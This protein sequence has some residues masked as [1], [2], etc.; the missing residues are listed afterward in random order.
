MGASFP[1]SGSSAL[2]IA[3]AP[4]QTYS[5]L[6][7]LCTNL[8]PNL[9]LSPT[10]SVSVSV[11]VVSGLSCVPS[12]P[13]TLAQNAA[14][15]CTFN[16]TAPGTL[17]GT[18]TPPQTVQFTGITN[19]QNDTNASNNIV[20]GVAPSGQITIVIDAIDDSAT[21]PS[22]T[23]GTVPLLPNDQLGTTTNPSVGVAG[24]TA[25]VVVPG[26]NTTLPGATIVGNDVVVQPGTPS[27]VYTVEYRICA[28]A[29]PTVCDT[30]IVT[31]TIPGPANV[32]PEKIPTLDP[33]LLLG[34]ILL[35][36]LLGARG[37][38][39]RT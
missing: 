17:G 13:A 1:A 16:Y 9:A 8:G 26:V 33:K 31:I 7:L 2:P 6:Q 24:V 30:A 29:A 21:I 27:G 39:R 28:Q 23:G 12:N 10:C 38:R 5:G 3:V 14:I 32:E 15:T 22:E 19:A 20:Q 37:Q 11:G 35:I 36:G 25:P 18:D 34:L 4:G